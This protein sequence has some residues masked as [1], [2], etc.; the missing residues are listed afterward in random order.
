MN[1]LF[2]RIC[3]WFQTV[4]PFSS[5][6]LLTIFMLCDWL[7]GTAFALRLGEWMFQTGSQKSNMQRCSLVIWYLG[8]SLTTFLFRILRL[9]PLH[10]VCVQ[11]R[12]T[13]IPQAFGVVKSWFS[14]QVAFMAPAWILGAACI[15]S[16]CGSPSTDHSTAAAGGQPLSWEV[17]K[18]QTRVALG[19]VNCQD[20]WIS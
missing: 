20:V 6:G 7:T 17:R 4:W 14:E 1:W 12:K 11:A 15:G 2:V 18:S 3:L 5:K 13:A 10:Q 16:V 9:V 8:L 19:S